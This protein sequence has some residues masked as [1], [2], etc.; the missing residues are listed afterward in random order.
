MTR[1]PVQSSNLK[2]IGYDP[3]TK[4]LEVEFHSGAVFHYNN[5]PSDHHQKLVGSRSPGAYFHTHIK[6]GPFGSKKVG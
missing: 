3:A 6:S 2:A 1:T 5:V 4:V